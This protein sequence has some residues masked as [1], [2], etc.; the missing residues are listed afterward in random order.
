MRPRLRSR[1][2]SGSPGHRGWAVLLKDERI[3]RRAAEKAAL[4]NAGVRAFVITRGDLRAE[5]MAQRFLVN[6][7]AITAACVEP[8]PFVFAV[9]Q[10]RIDRL[11]S[12]DYGDSSC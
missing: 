11:S 6:I 9:Q 4:V 7:E 1:N 3:R 10:T 12:T 2:R 5:Q 8:G